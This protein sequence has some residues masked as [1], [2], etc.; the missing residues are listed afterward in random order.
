M[1][2]RWKEGAGYNMS[3]GICRPLVDTVH[4]D[5]REICKKQTIMESYIESIRFFPGK[6]QSL[7]AVAEWRTRILQRISVALVYWGLLLPFLSLPTLCSVGNCS[8]WLREGWPQ[9]PWP[10]GWAWPAGY[11]IPPATVTVWGIGSEFSLR[12]DTWTIWTLGE[13]KG[14]LV[15]VGLW[16]LPRGE[17]LLRVKPVLE[18]RGPGRIDRACWH[19]VG[20]WVQPCLRPKSIFGLFMCMS[21]CLWCA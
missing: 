7:W 9:I 14:A 18:P 20:P 2:I 11:T 6:R 15:C 5:A 1:I 19:Y 4:N 8:L 10:Q 17:S 21:T 12:F 16:F 13:R 3:N